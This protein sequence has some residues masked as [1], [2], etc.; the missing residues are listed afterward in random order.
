MK[1]EMIKRQAASSVLG[2]AFAMGC[3][4]NATKSDVQLSQAEA[5]IE[6]LAERD[7]ASVGLCTAAAERCSADL[8]DAAGSTACA[9][10]TEE[11]A[12]LEQRLAEVRGPAVGC[13]RGV[14]AC[15]QNAPAEAECP[16]AEDCASLEEGLEEDRDPVV[17][18]A[19]RVEECLARAVETPESGVACENIQSACENI[20]GLAAEA[21]RARG[22]GGADADELNE[23]A[24]AALDAIPQGAG[25]PGAGGDDE[26]EDESGDA[27]EGDEAAEES[28]AEGRARAEA[29]R[30]AGGEQ[31]ADAT[32][33]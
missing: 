27:A 14:E 5:A 19:T 8:P 10:L 2:L 31:E 7:D 24:Q 26:D 18:C 3:G 1:L 17:E 12:N 32:D 6:A 21:A 22:E 28:A 29:A 9:R 30:A 25:N 16:A 20:G 13:W 4:S 33:D 15:E 11:C 23:R